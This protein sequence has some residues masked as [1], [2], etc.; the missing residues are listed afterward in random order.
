MAN[1]HFFFTVNI[2]VVIF[3]SFQT[4]YA[5]KNVYCKNI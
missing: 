2:P 3:F 4:E 5:K 1:L